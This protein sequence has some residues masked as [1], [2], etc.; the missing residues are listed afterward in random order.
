[1]RVLNVNTSLDFKTG[2]GTAERTFQM[3]RFLA[4][5]R[6]KCT[7]LTIDTGLDQARIQALK[8]AEVVTVPLLWRRFYIPLIKWS[9]IRQ[10]VNEADIVHLMGHWSVLNAIIYIAL[11]RA[12][13]PYVVCP[14]GALPLFGR[15]KQLKKLYN[16]F[17]GNNI[18]R[19]ASAWIAVTSAEFPHFESYGISA[20]QI[21]VLPNGVCREDFPL[22]DIDFFRRS[23]GLPNKPIILFMGRLNP[24]KGPDI[25]LKAFALMHRRIPD[26]HLV[27]AGPD[28][29]MQPSLVDMAKQEGLSDRIHFWGYVGG[30]DKSAAYRCAK[31][32]VVPSRQEAMSIVALEAGICGTPVLLTDQCGF[33]D[34][35]RVDSRLEVPANVNGIAK[36]LAGL[37]DDASVL[38][39]V[40]PVWHDFVE[41]HYAWHAIVPDYLKL[42]K[43]I[44][45]S[46]VHE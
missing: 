16:F 10:L 19:H 36:G 5:E 45:T 29:G 9:V 17:V 25:L 2:G 39:Q 12:R 3:S 32:L 13:K 6:I 8:P 35:C 11:R 7:V 14:A 37:L 26:Y 44:L 38:Q 41:Q 23:K 43:N 42:Y 22:V 40:A 30:N 31:L 27:F 20:E 28:E 4:Q 34:I 46:R 18:I 1:M 21:T 24:I 15:S 33:S